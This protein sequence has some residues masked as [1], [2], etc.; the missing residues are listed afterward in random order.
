MRAGMTKSLIRSLVIDVIADNGGV[1]ARNPGKLRVSSR[2]LPTSNKQDNNDNKI[3]IEVT[4][5]PLGPDCYRVIDV[6]GPVSSEDPKAAFDNLNKAGWPIDPVRAATIP[7]EIMHT[8]PSTYA[9]E[10][11]H[12][13]IT[14][15]L[16]ESNAET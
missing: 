12:A 11:D 14:F 15:H 5:Q 16:C 7:K 9:T 10:G 2:L 6:I 13:H 1:A 4:G 3:T 8:S